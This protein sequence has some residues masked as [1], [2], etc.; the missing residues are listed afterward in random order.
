M[1][2]G[3]IE[4]ELHIDATPD[5]VFE[6]LSQPEHIQDWW[7]AQTQFEPTAG[8]TGRLTWTGDGTVEEKSEPFTVVEADPPHRF[9]FRWIYD[10][11]DAVV[12]G[13]SLLVTFE[14]TADG[15]GTL[16]RFSETGY[17]E[18]GWEAATLEAYYNDH[19][20]GWDFL[21]P[22]VATTATRL[23]AAR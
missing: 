23:A 19:E 11:K 12:A 15:D 18:R 2:H 9:V 5:V 17:R 14:L 10:E 13:N 6:V 1:E 3:S 4:R 16:L 7:S 20:H 21:L 22:R 8:A